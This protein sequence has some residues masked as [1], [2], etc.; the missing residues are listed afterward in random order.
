MGFDT[1]FSEGLWDSMATSHCAHPIMTQV[2]GC[3]LSHYTLGLRVLSFLPEPLSRIPWT[4]PV[5]IYGLPLSISAPGYVCNNLEGALSLFDAQKDSPLQVGPKLKL[6][7]NIPDGDLPYLSHKLKAW[8]PL[9]TLPTCVLNHPYK[10][11]DV[12]LDSLRSPYRYRITKALHQLDASLDR[13]EIPPQGFNES[14]YRLYEAVYRRSDF[15]LEKA[16]LGFFQSFPAKIVVLQTKSKVPLGFYQYIVVGEVFY[17]VFC[18]IDYSLRDQYNTYITLLSD[19]LRTALKAGIATLDFGQTTELVKMKLGFK[20]SGRTILA[21]HDN[22]ILHHFIRMQAKHLSYR[23]PDHL[24][25]LHVFKNK[26][27]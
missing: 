17:F 4:Y 15:P 7:F 1:W 18:G 5:H 2:D 21:K 22:P 24:P 25:T 10:S 20:L 13:I 6:I 16:T 14:L 27:P 12:Y 9:Q 11:F 19:M 23:L 3:Y 8:I 26:Q